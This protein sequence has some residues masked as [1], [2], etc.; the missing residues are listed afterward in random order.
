LN[1]KNKSHYQDQRPVNC[2]ASLN[3]AEQTVKIH[4]GRVMQKL[5]VDSFAE[6]VRL[7]ET[8]GIP[9]PEDLK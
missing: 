8:A 4:R 5:K 3:I 6:L 9:L 2:A 7:A 1:L